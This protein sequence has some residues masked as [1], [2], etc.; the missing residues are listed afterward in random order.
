V[1]D[2]LPRRSFWRRAW[3]FVTSHEV[4][5]RLA[6]VERAIELATVDRYLAEVDADTAA[7]VS[8]L[9]ASITDIPEACVNLRSLLIVKYQKP[10]GPALIV[11]RLSLDEMLALE[12]YPEIL[13]RPREVM[14]LLAMITAAGTAIEDGPTF[15]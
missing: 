2:E 3:T 14:S 15:G 13:T 6:K 5:T 9:L 7:A 11:R 4:E 1:Y 12:R 8:E 10:S